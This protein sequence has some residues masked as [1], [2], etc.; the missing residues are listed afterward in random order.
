MLK[1]YKSNG[2]IE[3]APV[4]F[5]SST[6]TI[7]NCRYKLD[8][9][10]QE[11]LSRIDAWI[12]R[13]SGWIIELTESQ[14]INIS[15]YR[16]F[17]GS[18]YIGLPIESKH[19]K[20]GL[21]NIKNNDQKCFFWCHVRHIN[22]AKDHPG[23][24]KN[25]DRDFANNLDYDGIEFPVQEKDFSKIEVQ[26]NISVNVFGYENRLVFPIYISDQKFK[27]TKE[28]F[29]LINDDQSHYVY[30]KDFKTFM[31]HKTKNKNKK[32]FCKSC[33]QCFS[34][35]NVLIKHKED[36]LSI[37]GQQP[38]NLEKGTIEFKNYFKQLPVPF[39]IYANFECNLRNV[40]CYEGTYTKNIMS[41]FL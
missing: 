2:E 37:N 22:P 20:K 32:W 7:I 8:Q 27:D 41:M 18:S 25:I 23:K 3:F 15:T 16:S 31:F 33:L 10:F 4:Y 35:E 39:K 36:C 30:I 28:L 1:K 40:K 38:I 12:N 26:N 5:N 6:K 9:S 11:T 14:Y 13:G 21:I 29:L 17:V 34:S 19:P 24:N